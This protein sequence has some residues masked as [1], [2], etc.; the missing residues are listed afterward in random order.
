[1]AQVLIGGGIS[2]GDQACC[3][4]GDARRAVVHACKMP[5]HRAAVGY[6]GNLPS[7]HPEYLARRG[8]YDLYLNLID[9]PLPLFKPESFRLFLSFMEEQRSQ[10]RPVLIHCNQG[11]SR[12]PS[13][14]LL[15][16]AK[17]LGLFP[18]ESYGAARKAFEAVHPY[19]PGA[20]IAKFLDDHW[21]SL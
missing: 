11:Q 14:A 19:T 16:G 5:C 20:G 15:Y 7:G 2:F 9:P 1:M 21:S 10:G 17:R 18:S 12:A 3:A 6:E 13:L 8:E 4:P